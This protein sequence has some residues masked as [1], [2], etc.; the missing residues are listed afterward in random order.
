MKEK[1]TNI[2][3]IIIIFLQIAIIVRI[4]SSKFDVDQDKEVTA[5]DYI[6]IKEYIM[7]EQ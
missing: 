5:R 4:D 7:N 1:L 6:M 2:L 3:L